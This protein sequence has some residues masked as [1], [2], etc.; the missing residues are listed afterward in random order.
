MEL[1]TLEEGSSKDLSI[2]C[3]MEKY[4]LQA[5]KAREKCEIITSL[6]VPAPSS[7]LLKQERLH[8]RS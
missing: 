4:L 6:A 5:L 3:E 1:V 7:I 8:L 2:L